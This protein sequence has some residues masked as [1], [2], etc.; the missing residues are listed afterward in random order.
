MVPEKINNR[1]Q[2][3]FLMPLME[4]LNSEHPLLKLVSAI[5]WEN[6]EN[7]FSELY[8]G[9][10]G[11]PPK[12]V[13]LMIGLL[14]LQHMH[15]ISD[16]E[17]AQLW[18][19]NPYWQFFCGYGEFQLKFP[20]DPSSLARWRK[21]LGEAGV[22]KILQSTIEASLNLKAAKKEDFQKVI[23]DTTVMESNVRYPTDASLLNEIRAKLVEK[24]KESGIIL[25]QSYERLGKQLTLAIAGYCHAKQMK[26]AKKATR[27]LKTYLGRVMRDIER[28]LQDDPDKKNIFEPL[29]QMAQRLLEQKKDS[30]NK[31]YSLH[32]PE[33]YCVCKGKIR[34][35]Y[36]YWQKVSLVITHKQGL[37]VA[38]ETLMKNVH[39]SKTLA[40][41]LLKAEQNTSQKVL[42]SFVDRGYRG[43]NLPDFETKVYISGQRKN[44]TKT[45][46]KELKRRSAIEP[47]IGHMKNDGKLRRNFLKY[48]VGCR[49]NSVLCA[50]GHNLRLLMTFIRLIFAL[51]WQRL[52]RIIYQITSIGF[53]G[54]H[55][56]RLPS[57]I[58]TA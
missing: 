56:F 35:P 4:Q 58:T 54:G 39:D 41:A 7:E 15:G 19:E 57:Q 42:K 14:M 26:R 30:K 34:T 17:V 10:A 12:P 9:N 24:A 37:V 27:K 28:K 8:S 5:D 31:L 47:H 21:R 43:H 52:V 16:E 2:N 46:K 36:E 3:L 48:E 20:I 33:T 13:R 1:Q 45:L 32:S 23:V 40:G 18:V 51:F 29:L 38:A 50:I 11:H 6:L 22:N 55:N 25:R 53:H 49:L 44:M